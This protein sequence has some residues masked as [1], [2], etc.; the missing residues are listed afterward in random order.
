MHVASDQIG[1]VLQ[2][3]FIPQMGAWYLLT[4]FSY[5]IVLPETRRIRGIIIIGIFLTVIAG[6]C[7]FDGDFA[8]KKTI[9]FF[10]YFMAGYKIDELPNN[11]VSRKKAN[12]LL[13]ILLLL[14]IA[15]SWKTNWY[16]SALSILS[17]GAG[18]DTLERWYL[19]PA[20][21]FIC[22]FVTSLVILLVLNAIPKENKWLEQQGVDTMPMYLSHLILFMA[23][24]Y[25]VNK[26]NWIITVGASIAFTLLS[27]WLFSREW[28]RKTF[29][30]LLSVIK[31]TVFR[32][33]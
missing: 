32:E 15:I 33:E 17:R 14:L 28:Y 27:V 2:N 1:G 16:S 10:V 7:T 22:F 24:S 9:G 5:R 23:V 6:L 12:V 30:G 8:I 26:N 29:N 20:L 19:T 4:L 31:I 3:I 11:R 21:Y 18:F 25:L 13:I